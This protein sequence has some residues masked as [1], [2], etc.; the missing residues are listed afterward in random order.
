MLLIDYE[1]ECSINGNTEYLGHSSGQRLPETVDAL[2]KIG[3]SDHADVLHNIGITAA[4]GG[5]LPTIVYH[6]E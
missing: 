3:C 2:R 4:S 1:T 5:D 6:H